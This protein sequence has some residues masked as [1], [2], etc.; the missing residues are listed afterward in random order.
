MNGLYHY[1]CYKNRPPIVDLDLYFRDHTKL[2]TGP[3]KGDF[4]IDRYFEI[5]T[6]QLL[7]S[8]DEITATIRANKFNQARQLLE[9]YGP[10]SFE[11]WIQYI[12]FGFPTHNNCRVRG[13]MRNLKRFRITSLSRGPLPNFRY[14][15]ICGGF[16]SE[17]IK[18]ESV[19]PDYLLINMNGYLLKCNLADRPP[20]P[21]GG[22][23]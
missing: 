1:L 21:T 4:N 3:C 6:N 17:V 15:P 18:L 10:S 5:L 23:T 8:Q 7:D 13:F 2:L 12:V 22:Q 19:S 9:T 14:C 20:T 16:D 11:N